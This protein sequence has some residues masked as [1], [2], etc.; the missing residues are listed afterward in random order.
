MIGRAKLNTLLRTV[1]IALN[2][3]I[4]SLKDGTR[5]LDYIFSTDG[6]VAEVE[7]GREQQ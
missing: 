6:E 5:R 2:E 4:V 1:S 7:R 3:P